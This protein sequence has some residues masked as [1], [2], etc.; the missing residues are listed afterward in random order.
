MKM[1]NLSAR[2]R[3]VVKALCKGLPN[4]LIAAELGISPSTVRAHLVAVMR[5]LGVGSRSEVVINVFSHSASHDYQSDST[6][7]AE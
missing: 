7:A 4:K 5:K 2:E 1:A 6:R 3:E